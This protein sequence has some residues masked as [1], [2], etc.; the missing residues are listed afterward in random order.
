MKNLFLNLSVKKKLAYT[1]ALLGTLFLIVGGIG[2][3][4]MSSLNS[5][6]IKFSE[7]R[8][9]SVDLLLQSDRDMQQALVAQRSM[10]FAEVG[11]E[12]FNQLI[13]DYDENIQQARDR[14]NKFRSYNKTGL[15]DNLLSTFETN[16]NKWVQHSKSIIDLRKQNTPESTKKAID[17]SLNEGN[18]DFE[19]AREIINKLTEVIETICAQDTDSSNSLYRASLI[20]FS[21]GLIIIL[22]VSIFSSLK[23]SDFIAKPISKAAFMMTEL[24]KGHLNS[25][26]DIISNDETGK[27][28]QVQNKFAD[29]LQEFVKIMYEV[30][31]GNLNVSAPLLDDKDEISPALNKIVSTLNNLKTETDLMTQAS[32]DGRTDHRGNADKFK[33]GYRTILEG[34]NTSINEIVDV[35]RKGYV[36]MGKLANGD[37]TVRM[38]G[39]Y[40]GNYKTYQGYINNL[41]ESLE[42][43]VIQVTESVSA[44][45]SA[46]S[47]I[48]SSTEEMAA[49]IQEQSQQ[50]TEVAGAVEEMTKTILETSQ[51]SSAASDAAKNAGDIAREGGKVVSETIEGMIRIAEVVQNTAITVQELGN[52]SDQIGEIIQVIDDIADQTNLLALNAAIEAARA[53]EQGRGFAVVADEVRK[54]AERTTKATKEIASMIKQIQK[55][56]SGAVTSMAEGTKVVENG[57]V[58]ADKAG[59]SLT[60]IIKGAENVVDISVQVAAASEEQSSTSEQISKSIEAINNVTN[61]SSSGIQ[62]I[63]QAAEDLNKLTNNLELL[64][65]K[66]NVSN[67]NLQQGYEMAKNKKLIN[68]YDEV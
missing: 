50:T 28:I 57:K 15:D 67:N 35:V 32:I 3:Y 6:L 53:G 68:V 2:L 25:R 46:A 24:G 55:T 62:Q 27:L 23:I 1:F 13:K 47:Q 33:N 21:I 41:A 18:K 19:N 49:G 22:L 31:E 12:R 51:N 7:S 65:K 54:L 38:E 58:L 14:W 10:M 26:V 66:F 20:N 5:H 36:I 48:S 34:V 29:T 63:A 59:Q 52:S 11:S 40:K 44:T 61:Q 4:N 64:I 56:T 17:I 16:Y 43:L 8:L 45:A 42:S 37:L 9:P 30:S 39:E 60:Q